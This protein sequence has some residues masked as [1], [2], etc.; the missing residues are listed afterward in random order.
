MWTTCYVL[1]R[2]VTAGIEPTTSLSL[3]LRLPNLC[4]TARS[5]LYTGGL[6][7]ACISAGGQLPRIAI[8]SPPQAAIRLQ[9]SAY[10]LSC[11][12]NLRSTRQMRRS[13]CRTLPSICYMLVRFVLHSKINCHWCFISDKLQLRCLGHWRTASIRVKSSQVIL[14]SKFCHLFLT[15]VQPLGKYEGSRTGH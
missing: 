4:A 1:A 10:R 8:D 7:N 15:T 12:Y 11:R 13:L 2:V 9:L 14:C 5:S 6:V 3:L